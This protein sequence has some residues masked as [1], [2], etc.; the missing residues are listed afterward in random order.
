MRRAI[1]EWQDGVSPWADWDVSTGRA[2]AASARLVGVASDDVC[3]SAAISQLLAPVAVSL[4]AG[5]HVV[6]RLEAAGVRAADGSV[7]RSIFTDG[8][9]C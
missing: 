7:H 8:A 9:G 4:P 6:K 5:A 1:G 3:V 2:R